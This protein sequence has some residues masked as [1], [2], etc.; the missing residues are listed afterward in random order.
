MK[1]KSSTFTPK[2]LTQ[3]WTFLESNSKAKKGR[4]GSAFVSRSRTQAWETD[5]AKDKGGVRFQNRREKLRTEMALKAAG[6][7]AQRLAKE[8][9]GG[10]FEIKQDKEGRHFYQVRVNGKFG[11]RH[12]ISEKLAKSLQEG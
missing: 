2:G 7:T 6:R 4:K 8:Q 11:K 1:T 9:D 5:Q 10:E 12:Y 3:N